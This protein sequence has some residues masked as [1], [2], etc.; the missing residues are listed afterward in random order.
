MYSQKIVLA[1]MPLLSV[2]RADLV[3][4]GADVPPDCKAIC[5]PIIALAHACEFGPLSDGGRL[6]TECVCTRPVWDV[7]RITALCADCLRQHDSDEDGF[8]DASDIMK[9]CGFSS[10]SYEPAD[11]TAASGITVS[12]TSGVA[13]ATAATNAATAT[14]SGKQVTPTAAAMTSDSS[15]S[16]SDDSGSNTTGKVS[17][18]AAT[19]TATLRPVEVSGANAFGPLKAAGA[20]AVAVFGA[21]MTL[22]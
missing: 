5:G 3:L 12:T 14:G 18:N 11:A 9:T 13:I 19:A 20:A 16:N 21:I 2:A 10:T 6:E 7:S 4:Q 17:D 22:A 8:S 1:L 15:A